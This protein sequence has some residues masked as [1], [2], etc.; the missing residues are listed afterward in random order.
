MTA[1]FRR[2]CTGTR[3]A[4]RTVSSSDSNQRDGCW[5]VAVELVISS[6]KFASTLKEELTRFAAQDFLHSW[7][8]SKRGFKND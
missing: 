6:Q 4:G 2:N 5:V 7:C 8:E 1:M 3:E